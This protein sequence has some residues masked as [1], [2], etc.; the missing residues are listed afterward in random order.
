MKMEKI[1]T[2]IPSSI[3]LD[4]EYLAAKFDTSISNLMR[5]FL[6]KCINEALEKE[7]E[8][9]EQMGPV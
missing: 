1:S 5:A 9:N 6:Q 2:L 4:L 8:E 3:R 7:E